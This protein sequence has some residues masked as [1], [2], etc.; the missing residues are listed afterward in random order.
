MHNIPSIW[1]LPF[2]SHVAFMSSDEE[3]I[4]SNEVIGARIARSVHP[5]E[6]STMD[7]T[8]CVCQWSIR[9]VSIRSLIEQTEWISLDT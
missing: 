5:H 4:H 6:L 7:A 9:A 3:R 2:V 1:M 8:V